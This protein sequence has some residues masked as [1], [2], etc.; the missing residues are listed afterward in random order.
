MRQ[1]KS[2]AHELLWD[3]DSAISVFNL[4]RTV[5]C[6]TAGS[7]GGYTH[8]LSVFQN[9]FSK[10]WSQLTGLRWL[11][12]IDGGW[13]SPSECN[14][15]RAPD[16]CFNIKTKNKK[17][18]NCIDGRSHDTSAPPL[19]THVELLSLRMSTWWNPKHVAESCSLF[20]LFVCFSGKKFLAAVVDT[21]C[22]TLV[23]KKN[24][25][26]TQTCMKV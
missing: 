20:F 22:W 1:T 6:Q 23:M 9:R 11:V 25:D 5:F 17:K 7:P 24:M 13:Q 15:L 19:T 8:K 4:F 21:Q 16:K 12:T 10:P 2:Y 14:P 26:Y 3:P 18:I